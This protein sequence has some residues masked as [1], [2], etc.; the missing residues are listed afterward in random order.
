MYRYLNTFTFPDCFAAL[1]YN[2]FI[3]RCELHHFLLK[4]VDV[5]MADAHL[6]RIS[7]VSFHNLGKTPELLLNGLRLPDQHPQNTVFDALLVD[8]VMA[9]DL[10]TW[11]KLAVD[12]AVSLFH[13]AGVPRHV[14]MKQVMAKVFVNR[15][16]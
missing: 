3:L 16:N 6:Q 1:P 13:A 9:A 11:L 5:G 12:A 2:F 15:V 14:E 10:R 4:T 7:Q 8:E